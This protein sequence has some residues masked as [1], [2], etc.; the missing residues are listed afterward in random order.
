MTILEQIKNIVLKK[1]GTLTDETDTIEE[2]IGALA[3]VI[4]PG[5]GSGGGITF[6]NL[7]GEKAS[8]TARE[9]KDI[10]DNGGFVVGRVVVNGGS[11]V[12]FFWLRRIASTMGVT[13]IF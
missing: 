4:E 9:I 1:G 3:E 6:V 13:A 10:V 8:H 12:L 2:A 11:I 7:D 5:G